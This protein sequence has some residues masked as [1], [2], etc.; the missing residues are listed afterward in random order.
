MV[1][2][3]LVGAYALV[4]MLNLLGALHIQLAYS[5][6]SEWRIFW[7]TL[8]VSILLLI[9]GVLHQRERDWPSKLVTLLLVAAVSQALDADSWSKSIPQAVWVPVLV[10]FATTSLRW[11]V[12]VALINFG[13]L[14]W[15]FSAVGAYQY[16]VQI[17]TTT[18]MLGL[19]VV[20]RLLQDRALKAEQLQKQEVAR[21]SAEIAVLN[22][23]L[24]EKVAERTVQLEAATAG[25]VIAAQGRVLSEA[26]EQLESGFVLYSADDR[27]VACNQKFRNLYPEIAHLFVPGTS[28]AD[29]ARSFFRSRP[30][31]AESFTEDEYV[32]R[33]L[34]EHLNPDPHDYEYMHDGRCYLVT[35]RRM[36]DGGVVGLRI[37]IT[38]RKQAEEDL[39]RMAYYDSL[40]GLANRR[41]FVERLNQAV[42]SASQTGLSLAVVML[43]VER[44][45]HIN[46]TFGR[47]VGDSLLTQVANRLRQS[48][49]EPV[50]VA[51][52]GA[53]QFATIIYDAAQESMV[54]RRVERR[55]KEVFGL[56]FQVGTE[57]LRIAARLGIA[58]YPFDSDQ[59]ETLLAHSE[60]ALKRAKIVGEKYVFYRRE[61]TERV[62][63]RLSLE[64]RLRQALELQQ[65][66]LHYQPKVDTDHRTMVGLEALLRWNH[67]QDGLISP[68]AFIPLLEETGLIL[69][70]GAWALR[71][72][73]L[74]RK[75]WLAM[76]LS[77]PRIAVN[78]SA[79]Q[80]RKPDFV[81]VVAEQ[82]SHGAEEPGIDAEVTESLIMEDIQSNSE[83]LHALRRLGMDISIDDF[84][85]GY[86]SLAYLSK[87][88]TQ[89]LKI[90]RSF[91]STMLKDSD[92]LTLVSTM[93]TLAHSLRLK[94]VA[95][96]VETEEEAKML[97]LLRCDQM[98]GYLFSKPVP[99]DTVT[100]WLQRPSA[101]ALA[102]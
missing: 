48:G 35:D 59:P 29:I 1:L 20:A 21:K 75:A 77:A 54:A 98:Q 44:F 68:A 10:A 85:T 27:L 101:L 102:A 9:Q 4:S 78:V 8:A 46:D 51:R 32:V 76:G 18:L 100:Q 60:A 56:P 36:N 63:E 94:V 17:V 6:A 69:E 64:N 95:E 45:K 66:V 19:L 33:R 13:Y 37:D 97:Q 52:L 49:G 30:V 74:D 14:A 84:G 99:F 73:A 7:V 2:G 5:R 11:M 67:P 72:A 87:L 55:A 83:K 62:A 80:L 91:I 89:V 86:S 31:L 88:P 3:L 93:I 53:D 82:L 61:M 22:Q 40:T 38:E 15:H 42:Q 50:R 58:I 79:V 39:H 81:E 70:V 90:D 34:R 43:D 92:H 12:L 26:I 65:F 23:S 41:L 71:Q 57:Q 96:G 24:E 16:P 47:D 28:Y 25:L